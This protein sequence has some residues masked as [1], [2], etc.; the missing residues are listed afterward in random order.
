MEQLVIASRPSA[1]HPHPAMRTYSLPSPSESA[2]FVAL[3][4]VC[5][6][7]TTGDA[8]GV[9]DGDGTVDVCAGVLPRTGGVVETTTFGLAQS[10]LR[11]ERARDD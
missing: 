9:S 3:S 8:Y 1:A 2:W 6:R 5:A 4:A 11:D 10:L 7:R